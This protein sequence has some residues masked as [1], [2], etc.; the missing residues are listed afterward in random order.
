MGLM[1]AQYR[2]SFARPVANFV[3]YPFSQGFDKENVYTKLYIDIE[4]FSN[5]PSLGL[6]RVRKYFFRPLIVNILCMNILSNIFY[7]YLRGKLVLC[8]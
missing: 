2:F 5:R 4:Y 1:I 7:I 6:H 8:D 3:I